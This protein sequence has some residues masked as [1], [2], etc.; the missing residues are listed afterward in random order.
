VKGKNF[1]VDSLEFAR[2]KKRAVDEC[3]Y[4]LYDELRFDECIELAFLQHLYYP[5]DEFYLYFLVE[6]LH[7]KVKCIKY[8]G[9]VPFITW[10]YNL[11]YPKEKFLPYCYESKFGTYYQ[12]PEFK[13][14]IFNHLKSDIYS[15]RPDEFKQ[16]KN[17]ELMKKDTIAFFT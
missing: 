7:S 3:I 11:K 13:N 1:Q 9:E 14:S 10:C 12:S 4:L 6:S 5:D 17:K 8:Y 15:L 16:I 2:V